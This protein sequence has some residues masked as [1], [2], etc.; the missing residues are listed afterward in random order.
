MYSCLV[1]PEGWR[2]DS[3]RDMTKTV[4]VRVG[5][6]DPIFTDNLLLDFVV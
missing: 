2:R 3:L 1:V 4:D 5:T 6:E